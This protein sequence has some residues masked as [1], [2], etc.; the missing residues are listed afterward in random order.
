VASSGF[1]LV[2][3]VSQNPRPKCCFLFK[4]L[5]QKFRTRVPVSFFKNRRQMSCRQALV[6]GNQLPIITPP[7]SIINKS[8]LIRQVRLSW[9]SNQERPN[10]S[11]LAEKVLRR[12]EVMIFEKVCIHCRGLME[13]RSDSS[14]SDN[15]YTRESDDHP[16]P[17]CSI[18]WSVIV[19]SDP[20][21]DRDQRSWQSRHLLS[22][23]NLP[24]TPTTRHHNFSSD[25]IS[26]KNFSLPSDS[27]S[28]G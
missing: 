8:V 3:V 16:T 2:A 28:H 4:L 6:S 17:M 24:P 26:L 11:L 23:Q 9:V 25:V 19:S 20:V 22:L 21:R 27:S 7:A 5:S 12:R 15:S 18:V 1:S 10:Q 14:P 13:A